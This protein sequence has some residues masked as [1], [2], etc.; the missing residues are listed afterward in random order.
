V[1]EQVGV[2]PLGVEARLLGQG[3]ENQEGARAGQRPTARVQVELRPVAAVEK[4]AAPGE[5]P[6]ERLRG[7]AADRYDPL[8]VAL[9]DDAHEPVVQ[10][11]PGLL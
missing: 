10:V 8:L 2:D 9:P 4:R 6:A 1:A 3:A 7:V 11:D 5:V